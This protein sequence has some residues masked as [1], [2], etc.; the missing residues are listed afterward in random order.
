MAQRYSVKSMFE[1]LGEMK[2]IEAPKDFIQYLDNKIM[3]ITNDTKIFGAGMIF[4]KDA[5]NEARFKMHEDEIYLLP[6]SIHEILA[7]PAGDV[8]KYETMVSKVN[9]TQVKPKDLLSYHVF[10]WD[11]QDLKLA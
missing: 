5:L 8:S 10:K 1:T 6:S 2:G 4:C 3:F 11:G 7:V 9:D